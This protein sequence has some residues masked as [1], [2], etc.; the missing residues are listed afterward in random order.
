[1]DWEV[2]GEEGEGLSWSE[3]EGWADDNRGLRCAKCAEGIHCGAGGGRKGG[4][5]GDEILAAFQEDFDADFSDDDGDLECDEGTR[6]QANIR[7]ETGMRL[8]VL[9]SAATNV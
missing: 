9:G 2:W 6:V 3:D 5:D 7:T 4:V 1:V 8:A